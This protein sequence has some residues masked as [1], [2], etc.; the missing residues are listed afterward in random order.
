M[1]KAEQLN[2]SQTFTDLFEENTFLQNTARGAIESQPDNYYFN[3]PGSS[4]KFY[5]SPNRTVVQKDFNGLKIEPFF[6]AGEIIR[7]VITDLNG[8]RY[9][10]E[11][12]EETT[13]QMADV[14]EF[15]SALFPV[16]FTYRFYSSWFLTEIISVT[17]SERIKFSYV[18]DDINTY[19]L[20]INLE[21]Y[22]SVSY[23]FDGNSTQCCGN[24]NEAKYNLAST[25]ESIIRYRKHLSQILYILGTDTLEIIDFIAS[26]NNCSDQITDKKL[27]TIRVQRGKNGTT[28]IWDFVFSYDCSIGRLTLKQLLERQ[29]SPSGT[30][31]KEPYRFSYNT[32]TL[33]DPSYNAMDHWGYY[34]GSFNS[35]LIPNLLKHIN[36]GGNRN[37]D[38]YFTRAGILEEVFYPTGGFSC[39]EYERHQVENTTDNA[40]VS[41]LRIKTIQHYDRAGVLLLKRSYKYVQANGSNVSSGILH[42][43]VNYINNSTFTKYFV[44]SIGGNPCEEFTC[45]NFT[46]SATNRSFLGAVQGDV[47]G[48]SRVEEI[49]ESN[50]SSATSG[51]TVCFYK[52]QSIDNSDYDHFGYDLMTRKEVY[53]ASNNII[54]RM[55]YTY[56]VDTMQTSNA[57]GNDAIENRI[58]PQITNTFKATTQ[59]N[60][61]NKNYLCR[62]GNGTFEWRT[63]SQ[64]IPIGDYQFYETKFE[65]TDRHLIRRRW[66][67]PKREITTRYFYDTNGIQNGSVVTK[68]FF[69]YGDT[70]F[71]A[72]TRTITINSDNLA[73]ESQTEYLANQPSSSVV[74]S[75]KLNNR[76]ATPFQQTQRI[77]GQV[78]YKTRTEYANFGSILPHKIYEFFPDRGEFLSEVVTYDNLGNPNLGF[79][80]YKQDI[81][82][83]LADTLT[84]F[85]PTSMLWSHYGATLAA[86]VQN[87]DQGEIAYTS[88]EESTTEQG[89]WNITNANNNIKFGPLT[90][91]TG[92]GYYQST[93]NEGLTRFLRPGK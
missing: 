39:Y 48:Y 71:N 41:G 13:Y 47:I 16:S 83:G 72:P 62:L 30:V 24:P 58:N 63:T 42:Q 28:S 1:K 49:I 7:F 50:I 80:H 31:Q 17:A 86:R 53:D 92:K 75:L 88:F 66:I 10:F 87:A 36:I 79:R 90:A 60:Q 35:Q 26:S 69:V 33:P 56:S 78:V 12:I 70:T 73:Y 11:S 61:D 55:D 19:S 65:R 82:T 6:S 15:S 34:N 77:N 51:K 40:Y 46:I 68:Q 81:P 43:P 57:Y 29:A 93:N 18:S 5:I 3:F 89:N 37:P 21:T 74:E 25:S 20:P 8:T 64:G 32:T 67:Y 59:A 45:T 4:G 44:G 27:D 22:R 85:Q 76:W 52:N 91:R 84:Y 54:E 23:G 9:I 2:Q 14:A 38:E